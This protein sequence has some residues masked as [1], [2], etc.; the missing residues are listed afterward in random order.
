MLKNPLRVSPPETARGRTLERAD[1][2]RLWER[3]AC[4][5]DVPSSAAVDAGLSLNRGGMDGRQC[6]VTHRQNLR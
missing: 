3:E 1:V 2:G 4:G 6:R 5:D